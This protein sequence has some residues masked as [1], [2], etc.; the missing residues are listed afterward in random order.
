[1]EVGFS[2]WLLATLRPPVDHL[3]SVYQR[4]VCS[5]VCRLSTFFPAQSG[6]VH[7]SLEN[8]WR[9][10]NLVSIEDGPCLPYLLIIMCYYV[11]FCVPHRS[12]CLLANGLDADDGY[13]LVW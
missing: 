9:T 12:S 13:L 11:L 3:F 4:V 5:A 6:S 8:E 1:M 7:V 10:A 2:S